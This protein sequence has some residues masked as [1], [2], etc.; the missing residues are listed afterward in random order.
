MAEATSSRR[1]RMSDFVKDGYLAEQLRN[2][3]AELRGDQLAL[4]QEAIIEVA[5]AGVPGSFEELLDAYKRGIR[6]ALHPERKLVKNPQ[7]DRKIVKNPTMAAALDRELRDVTAEE[8]MAA[9]AAVKAILDQA[10]DLVVRGGTGEERLVSHPPS[11]IC[12][13]RREHSTLPN[14]DTPGCAYFRDPSEWLDI[15]RNAVRSAL[16]N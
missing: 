16:V 3:M 6:R 11:D 1:F 4:A 10:R 8:L 2:E 5:T 7:I 14:G 12:P 13:L 15:L 9:N